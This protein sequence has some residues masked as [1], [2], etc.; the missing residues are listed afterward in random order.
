MDYRSCLAIDASFKITENGDVVCPKSEM[1]VRNSLERAYVFTNLFFKDI[2]EREINKIRKKILAKKDTVISSSSID[3]SKVEIIFPQI[4]AYFKTEV[5]NNSLD[6]LIKTELSKI[7]PHLSLQLSKTEKMGL[8][9]MYQSICMLEIQKFTKNVIF[10]TD[11]NGKPYKIDFSEKYIAALP[12]RAKRILKP[13]IKMIAYMQGLK[14]KTFELT[15]N[16]DLSYTWEEERHVFH[17]SELKE[18]I[19]SVIAQ[20]PLSAL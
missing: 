19:K 2:T 20:K 5:G 9:S 17:E 8:D 4:S 15:D 13:T 12:E 7:K 10:T 6:P 18:K 3:E 1:I 11:N 14:F 16:Y